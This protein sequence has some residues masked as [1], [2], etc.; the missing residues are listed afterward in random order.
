MIYTH[1]Q[2]LRKDFFHRQ[3]AASKYGWEQTPK[4]TSQCAN[5]NIKHA[6]S[7]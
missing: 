3:D 5:P 2:Q 6:F 4:A 7:L 1:V